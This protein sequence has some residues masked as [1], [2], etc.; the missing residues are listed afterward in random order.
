MNAPDAVL[1]FITLSLGLEPDSSGKDAIDRAVASAMRHEG[2]SDPQAFEK[3]FL[4]SPAVRQKLID[5]VVVGETWFFRDRGP[6]LWLGRHALQWQA[7][8][9]GSVLKILSSPCSTGEEPY[10]IV[11]TLLAAGLPPSAFTVEGVDVSARALETAGRACY[12]KNAFRGNIG[13]DVARF[14]EATP[15]GRKVAASVLNRV[16]FSLENLALPGSL[17]GR[18][19]YDI[20][21]CRNLLIYMTPEARLRIF[22]RMDQLLVPGGILFA[23]HTETNFW[24]QR[25]YQLL[26]WDR[27]FALAKP[28]TP[29]QPVAIKTPAPAKASIEIS[30][31]K[32][33]VQTKETTASSPNTGLAQTPTAELRQPVKA[34]PAHDHFNEPQAD[35]QIREARRLADSGDMKGAARLC[36]EYTRKFGPAAEA[37]CLMGI[38]SMAGQDLNGAEDCFLKALYL[39]PGHYESLVHISLIYRQKGNE[40]KA[41][42]Y[43]ERAERTAAARK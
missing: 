41:A 20:I 23:G 4:S 25:G 22:D 40:K 9:P 38:L 3:L 42:L 37:Y 21:F 10:S 5:A 18:G 43:R 17:A 31:P 14:F 11:M 24:H 15:S 27:A 34:G 6:F 1:E 12:P 26:P 39:D 35:A 33:R 7:A 16:T 13:E 28:V 36:R 19:P 29:A 2:L 8:H 32:K 30:S